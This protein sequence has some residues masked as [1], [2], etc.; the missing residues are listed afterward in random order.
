M[1]SAAKTALG[2]AAGVGVL[3]L[4]TRPGVAGA[5][6]L[7]TSAP[8]NEYGEPMYPP[9]QHPLVLTNGNFSVDTWGSGVGLYGKDIVNAEGRIVNNDVYEHIVGSGPSPYPGQYGVLLAS[10]AHPL[11]RNYLKGTNLRF[12]APAPDAASSSGFLGI[13]GTVGEGLNTLSNNISGAIAGAV[14]TVGGSGTS[15]LGGVVAG[16]SGTFAEIINGLVAAIV[17]LI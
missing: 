3:Y 6:G 11:F 15:A 7:F 9:W 13:G 1:N 17:A 4:L 2:V 10:F 14:A 16:A 8:L 5:G 12:Y